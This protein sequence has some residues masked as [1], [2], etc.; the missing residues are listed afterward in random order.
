MEASKKKDVFI[1]GQDGEIRNVNYKELVFQYAIQTT[2]PNGIGAVYHIRDAVWFKVGEGI[3]DLYRIKEEAEDRAADILQD[4][5]N[6]IQIV[7]VARFEAWTWG[8]S[9]CNPKY[10]C[11]FDTQEQADQWLFECAQ[12]DFIADSTAPMTFMSEVEAGEWKAANETE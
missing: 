6:N 5:G 3:S 1:I 10:I 4:T 12:I 8:V 11:V 2:T 9:G 7:D